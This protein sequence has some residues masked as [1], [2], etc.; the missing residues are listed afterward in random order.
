MTFP[1]LRPGDTEQNDV[2]EGEE[3]M[4]EAVLISIRPKWCELIAARQ[5]TIEVRKTRPKLETPFKC[6]IYCT[7]DPG[8]EGIATHFY[9]SED[10][11][12]YSAN[13]T[14]KAFLSG[15]IIG[16]FVCNNIYRFDVPFPAYQEET[17][18]ATLT[19]ACLTYGEAHAY[20]GHDSG[21][22]WH[23]SDLVIYDAPKELRDFHNPYHYYMHGNSII[24]FTRPPQSWCYV[25]DMA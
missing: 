21:W 8:N 1:C 2:F 3:E 6:Y 7:K 14:Y 19:A 15:T 13:K 17:D 25:E 4:S 11:S 10:G 23:I 20:L 12:F 9:E 5:K 18:K 16:E 22:A 24:G